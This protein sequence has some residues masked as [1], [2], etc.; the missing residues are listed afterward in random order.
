M[1]E[2]RYRSEGG[3]IGWMASNPI[4]AN[5]LMLVVFCA[6]L[7]SL[8]SIRKE[9]F[10]SFPTDTFTVTVP[11]PGSSPEEVEQGVIIKI[12]EALRDIVGIEEIRSVAQEGVGVVTVE[13][14]PGTD[15][16]RA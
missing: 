11:Y 14:Q 8:G 9:V 16:S 13:M 6:G 3:I 12:E 1:A 4:A 5:L 10:P 2:S 15:L 7:A